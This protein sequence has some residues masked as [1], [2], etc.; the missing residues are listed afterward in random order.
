MDVPGIEIR[1][2]RKMSG[3]YGFSEVLFNDVTKKQRGSN[4]RLT[5]ETD[6]GSKGVCPGH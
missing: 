1:A 6:F 2:I 5:L 4:P 3:E